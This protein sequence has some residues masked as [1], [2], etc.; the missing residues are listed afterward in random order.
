MNPPSEDLKA[1]LES[2]AVNAGTYAA[3]SGWSI[4]IGGMPD[5]TGIPDTVIAIK[6]SGGYRPASNYVLQ[7]PAV[8]IM[9]RGAKGGYEAAWAKAEEIRDALHARTNE[10][11]G[12]TRYI[13]I[14][15][16][17]E[18]MGLGDDDNNRPLISLNFE[19]ERTA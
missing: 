8:Q 1:I 16:S 3:T 18:I 19:I 5:G 11:W 9:I 2:S 12:S 17:S 10:T 6:D 14:L 7:K 13:Q 4:H 15:C